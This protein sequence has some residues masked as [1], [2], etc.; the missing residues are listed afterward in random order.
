MGARIVILGGGFGGI[1]AA[2]DLRRRL[3]PAHSVTLVERAPMFLMGL[4]KIWIISGRGTRADG[5]RPLDALRRRGV[6][7]RRALVTRI[8][9]GRRIVH[10]D[11]GDVAFDYLLIALGAEPRPDLVPGFSDAVF[12]LYAGAEAERLAA[13][14]RD[15]RRGRIVVGVLGVPYKCPPAPYEAAMVLDDVIRRRRIRQDVELV[16]YT[17]QPMSLPVVGAAGCAQVEGLL[18]LKAI[19]FTPNRK[20][21]RLD[22]RTAVFEDGTSLSADVFIGVPPHRPPAVVRDSGLPRRG[23]WLEVDVRTMRTPHERIYAVGDVVEIPLANQMALPKAGV[24]AEAQARV[25][26]AAIAAALGGAPPE[27]GFTGEGYCFIE[28]GGGQ[29]AYVTGNFLAAP[30]PAIQVT[31]PSEA[32]LAEKIEFERTRL[33]Q[34]FG[35]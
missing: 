13:A 4:R 33:A 1:T 24:F 21:V 32:S 22:G 26:A 11:G 8:D 10:T 7:V 28:V 27:A 18:A 15:F 9:V 19:G 17:P 31:P 16:T 35:S 2:L 34:W 12:N 14:L 20:T 6:D 25:A 29:A 3:D 23:E 5:E 30:A